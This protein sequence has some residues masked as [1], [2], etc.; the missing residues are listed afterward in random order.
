ME[1]IC[2]RSVIM[3]MSRDKLRRNP[4]KHFELSQCNDA[5]CPNAPSPF[6]IVADDNCLRYTWSIMSHQHSVQAHMRMAVSDYDREIR[7]LIPGYEKM[8]STIT[9]WLSQVIPRPDGRIIE[10]G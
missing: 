5:A 4:L 6:L 9:S 10:L 3:G 2:D 8:L 1:R 7:T